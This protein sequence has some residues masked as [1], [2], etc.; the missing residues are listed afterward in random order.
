[1]PELPEAEVVARQVR[2]HLVGASLADMWIGRADIIR[3]G[4]PSWQWYL[5]STL[6]AVERRGKSVVLAFT[7]FE[8]TRFLVA[9]LGMTGLLLFEWARTEYQKHTHLRL[10]F[11]GGRQP[12]LCYWNPRRF[13]RVSLLDQEGLEV[14]TRRRFGY[15]PTAM[16]WE[17]F[18]DILRA[19]R[20]RLKNFLLH[21]QL[22]AG[23]G[24]IYAN[25][26]LFRARLH[27]H[28]GTHRVPQ[29]RARLLYE[30]IRVVLAEAIEHGG[31]SI[32]DFVAP[33]GTR[34]LY[35]GHHLVYGHAEE[36][37]PMKCGA[38]IRALKS[39]RTSFYCPRCQRV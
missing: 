15:D 10:L 4:L 14:Y 19:R 31:S 33:D 25:E 23:I 9:E 22:I 36:S 13:G 17:Q 8:E 20:V 27:P 5:R 35:A 7:K 18:W 16:T 24:N 37:C 26:A 12:E 30:A 28:R 3:E 1:M 11:T 39:E 32:R 38:R 6:T 2:D 34:G 21:Q 29:A